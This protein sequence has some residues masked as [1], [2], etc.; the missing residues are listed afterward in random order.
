MAR[1]RKTKQIAQRIDPTY[2]AKSHPWRRMRK[3]I[4]FL[5]SALAIAYVAFAI[6]AGRLGEGVHNPGKLTSAHKMFEHDCARCHDGLADDGKTPG[7]FSKSVSDTACLSCH[8][9]AVHHQNQATMAVIDTKSNPHKATASQ[10][11]VTCHTEHRGE[12]AL[13]G[14]DDFHCTQCH[15]NLDGKT[16]SPPAPGMWTSVTGFLPES[17]PRFGRSLVNGKPD[18]A[19]TK[20]PNH[21][22]AWVLKAGFKPTDPTVIRFNHKLHMDKAGP[23]KLSSCTDCHNPAAGY[24]DKRTWEG[25]K[26]AYLVQSPTTQP[27]DAPAALMDASGHRMS[28]GQV[29]YDMNCGSCHHP[30]ASSLGGTAVPHTDMAQVRQSILGL[31][32]NNKDLDWN[33]A[34]SGVAKTTADKKPR[35]MNARLIL[36]MRKDLVAQ[37]KDDPKRLAEAQEVLDY[38]AEAVAAKPIVVLGGVKPTDLKPT[39]AT[40]PSSATNPPKLPDL[41]DPRLLQFYAAY[42]NRTNSCFECHQMQGDP[43]AIPTEWKM[44]PTGAKLGATEL[45][46]S[47]PTSQPAT[48]PAAKRAPVKDRFGTLAFKTIPTGIPAGPRRWYVD[49]HFSHDAH[50]NMTCV[51]CHASALTSSDTADILSPDITW[52][53]LKLNTDGKLEWASRSCFECHHEENEHGPGAPANCTECHD[54]H[55]RM[56]EL[57]DNPKRPQPVVTPADLPPKPAGGAAPMAT[58]G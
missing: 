21:T 55:D 4:I 48:A 11:C 29:S 46:E 14:K 16:I 27:L 57:K 37:Y 31:V 54:F 23:A 20:D 40:Q 17:H 6:G 7:K 51:E 45:E 39:N 15:E 44:L 18:D 38:V 49:S 5:C 52:D 3:S 30:A 10:S 53:G 22:G 24:E 12:A 47:A 33:D 28:L 36:R 8:Q 13:M 41:P 19:W 50:R 34:V 25:A 2:F 56:L 1:V 32:L 43:T 58:A 35:S 9:G 42:A 26:P